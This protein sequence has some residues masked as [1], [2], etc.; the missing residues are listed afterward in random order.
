MPRLLI[1]IVV[2]SLAGGSTFGVLTLFIHCQIY[3][4]VAV[5]N[6]DWIWLC[7]TQNLNAFLR[8]IEFTP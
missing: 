2:A 1:Q 8:I 5:A 7:L 4:I 6:N 3:T